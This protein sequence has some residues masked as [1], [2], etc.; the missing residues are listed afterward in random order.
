M[1]TSRQQNSLAPI[2]AQRSLWSFISADLAQLLAPTSGF[3]SRLIGRV[4]MKWAP[5][6]TP[7]QSTCA[8]A[9]HFTLLIATVWLSTR[10]YLGVIHDSRFYTIQALSALLPGRFD[11]DLYFQYGSA[12]QFTLF[13]LAY[14]PALAIFG[15]AESAMVL[16]VVGQCLWIGGLLFLAHS[17]FRE[18]RTAL[19]AVTMAVALPGG[20]LFNYGE[21]F[22]T[23][24]LFA[25]GITLL[26]LGSMLRNRPV[27]ALVLLGVSA[28]VHPIMTLPGLAALCLYQ[29]WAERVWRALTALAVLGLLGFAFADIEPFARV[30]E[31]FDPEWFAIVRVRDF[32]CLLAQWTYFDWLKTANVFILAALGL[33]VAHPRQRRFLIVLLAVAVGGLAVTLIASSTCCSAIDT[34]A[35]APA[36]SRKMPGDLVCGIQA[37]RR[38]CKASRIRSSSNVDDDPE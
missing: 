19:I 37:E 30:R 7:K 8:S 17:I 10:P 9:V 2:M 34:A 15:V 31:S 12:D 28:T 25:E 38:S 1:R 32:F 21:Q 27:R 5:T 29:A 33:S 14:K 23:P 3:A 36:I 4:A 6:G 24:R 13:T 35:G 18:G 20:A 22:L 16:T 11:S 26:A